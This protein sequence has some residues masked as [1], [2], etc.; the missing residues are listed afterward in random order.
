VGEI[1]GREWEGEETEEGREVV[2]L[3][4]LSGVCSAKLRVE[5]RGVQCPVLVLVWLQFELVCEGNGSDYLLLATGTLALLCGVYFLVTN[6]FG[7]GR[8]RSAL[9]CQDDPTLKAKLTHYQSKFQSSS[10]SSSGRRSRGSHGRGR[11]R[12]RGGGRGRGRVGTQ[13]SR[14]KDPDRQGCVSA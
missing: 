8:I 5:G 2:S 9:L 14:H 7:K 3:A 10:S 11:G 4:R 13:G 1:I 12:G 6:G